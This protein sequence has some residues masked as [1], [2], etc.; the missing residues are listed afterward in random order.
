M[1]AAAH[2]TAFAA[3]S[4]YV[5]TDVGPNTIANRTA[6]DLQD[7]AWDAAVSGAGATRHNL[8]LGTAGIAVSP[9]AAQHMIGPTPD[10]T[11][12]RISGRDMNG[13][14]QGTLTAATAADPD[15]SVSNTLQGS[16]PRPASLYAVG[17]QPVFWNG[18]FGSNAS[19]NAILF[20]F[21]GASGGACNLTPKPT[22]GFGAWFGDLETSAGGT[23]GEVVTFAGGTEVSRQNLSDANDISATCT[24]TNC[25][26][27][28]TRW[29]SF[30]DAATPTVTAMLV[31]VGDNATG[32]N[33]NLE[34]LSFIGPAVAAGPPVL[35]VS[36]TVTSA[37]GVNPVSYLVTVRNT[38]LGA[39]TYALSD[40][41]LPGTGIALGAATCQSAQNTAGCPTVAAPLAGAGPWA[42]APAGT[43]IAP[44]ATHSFM[45]VQS[46]TTLANLTDTVGSG[47]CAV[48]NPLSGPGGMNNVA[49]LTPN[50][51]AQSAANACLAVAI[52]AVPAGPAAA[53]TTAVPAL[54]AWGMALLATLMA[55]M[56]LGMDSL[57]PRSVK[58]L[59]QSL[60]KTKH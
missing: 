13:P 55:W 15:L 51:A 19:R 32:G 21:F 18:L 5:S 37:A 59:A 36:K 33:G 30:W 50:G 60:L 20:E 27:G 43:A 54:S 9:I 57:A 44:G 45:L 56:A 49:T 58:K 16:A 25:G 4:F 40:N 8:T 48:V 52:P 46:Y 12:V 10:G 14:A 22:S 53:N 26:N 1:C 7:N 2:A 23:H 11:C 41:P 24:P 17:A 34:S 6:V 3:P 39:G 31:M 38:G 29:V 47:Q 35:S 42:L 28:T